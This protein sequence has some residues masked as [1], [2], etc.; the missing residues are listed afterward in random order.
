MNSME[1]EQPELMQPIWRTRCYGCHRPIDR[2]FCDRIPLIDNKTEIV[3]LQHIRERFHPFNTARI[4]RRAL[5]HSRLLVD[6]SVRLA[7]SLS[8]LTISTGAGLLYPGPGSVL[9]SDL[10]N[11]KRPNQLVILDGTWHHTKT[12][13]RDIPQ[14]QQLPRY[15]LAPTQPS[16]YRIRREPNVQF[17]STLEATVA[18]LLCLEPET[19]GL[20]Q[21]IATFEGMI[22]SQLTLPQAHYGVRRHASRSTKAWKNLPRALQANLEQIVVVYGET[23][24]ANNTDN[25]ASKATDSQMSPHRGPVYWVA[26]RLVT[27]E[28]F[29]Q[30]IQAPC[31]F[32]ENFLQHLALPKNAFENAI[33]MDAFR[34]LWEAFLRPNDRLA[35]YY[36]NIPKLLNDI[37]GRA[38]QPI[39]LKSIR[40]GEIRKNKT[41]EQLLAVLNIVPPPTNHSG[42]AGKRLANT[43]ALTQYFTDKA[44]NACLPNNSLPFGNSSGY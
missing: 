32:S 44:I 38:L 25:L 22:Q 12:L 19:L 28:R 29:E 8:Q 14:L 23:A 9:L 2:C 33:S 43:I 13:I 4:V 26:E 3:I 37:G 35:F 41:L 36:S 21:L 16:R 11:E 7:D 18:A 42:R 24:P 1:F 27:G 31:P 20:D 17:I 5:S 30:A 40:L 10:P 34:Q 6:H 39:C 15:R